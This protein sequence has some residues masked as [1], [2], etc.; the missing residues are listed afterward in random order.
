M[1]LEYLDEIEED[2]ELDLYKLVS[3]DSNDLN[4]YLLFKGSNQ[5]WYALNVS[6]IEEVLIFDT[7]IKVSHN[8]DKES[9]I[10]GTADIRESMTPLIYFDAWYGNE[11]L[12]ASEYE[13]IIL[14]Y[15]GGHKMGIVVKEVASICIIEAESMSDNSQNNLKSTFISKVL[16]DGEEQMC[17]IY[18]GDKMLL[19]IF[20]AKEQKQQYLFNP[21][22]LRQLKGKMV[23][24]AD[25]SRFVRKLVEDLLKA[26]GVEYR[27]FNDGLFLM[28]YLA[29]HPNENVSLFITDLE[30]PNLG[31][32]EVIRRIR[33][34]SIYKE[35]P[36]LVHTNMSNNA[37]ESELFEIGANDIIAKINM[38]TLGNAILKELGE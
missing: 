15:Y 8:S 9:Y 24:F 11:V 21:D 37:M 23:L 28:E 31:G 18:D 32:R 26:L 35:T 25:D 3:T 38:L 30:M 20:D 13:L 2:D 7:S 4:Q 16:I 33:E 12:D 22:A 19:D 1:D 36:I 6:K 27:I 14:A 29:S 5:E 10:F 34:K 17:T